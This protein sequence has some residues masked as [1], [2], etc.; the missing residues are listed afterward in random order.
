MVLLKQIFN[1]LI[2]VYLALFWGFF[3]QSAN[4][5]KFISINILEL[6]NTK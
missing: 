6:T 2:V 5:Y 3:L 1:W 4:A